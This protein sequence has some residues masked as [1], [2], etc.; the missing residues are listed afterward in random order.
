MLNYQEL[1]PKVAEECSHWV[2]NRDVLR[3]VPRDVTEHVNID[4]TNIPS[5]LIL[6]RESYEFSRRE[7]RDNGAETVTQYIF[8]Q[9]IKRD[10]LLVVTVCGN[11]VMATLQVESKPEPYQ[12]TEEPSETSQGFS[13]KNAISQAFL[14]IFR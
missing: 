7:I 10:H 12:V 3:A 8:A 6:F 13:V 4:P 2:R 14:A 1:N 5:T 9:N 11:N